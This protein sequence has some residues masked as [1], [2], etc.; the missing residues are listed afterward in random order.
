MKIQRQL[1]HL[2]IVK[3]I[4]FHPRRKGQVLNA[5]RKGH[6]VRSRSDAIANETEWRIPMYSLDSFSYCSPQSGQ[7]NFG[8]FVFTNELL[9]L[10]MP[11]A[12]CEKQG[13]M[14]CF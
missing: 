14:L 8:F 11:S 1:K 13:F 2:R 7:V 5:L 6:P 12:I 9:N 4:E 10:P 3:K